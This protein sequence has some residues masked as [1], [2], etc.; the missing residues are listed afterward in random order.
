MST[1]CPGELSTVRLALHSAPLQTGASLFTF[2]HQPPLE[3]PSMLLNEKPLQPW[4][5]NRSEKLLEQPPEELA[6]DLIRL[7]FDYAM[8]PHVEVFN[9]NGWE[10]VKEFYSFGGIKRRGLVPEGFH[11]QREFALME[12]KATSNVVSRSMMV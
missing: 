2:R 11:W 10:T 1:N 12:K 4:E 8:V 6:R 5:Y 7:G 3:I 9:E